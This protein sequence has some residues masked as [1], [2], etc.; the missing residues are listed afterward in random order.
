MKVRALALACAL[1][2]C[3]DDAGGASTLDFGVDADRSCQTDEGVRAV[4]FE[5]SCGTSRCHD[6]DRPR[7]D[8]D[9]VSDGFAER[10]MSATSVHPRCRE[11]ALVLPGDPADSLLI[12]KILGT[13]GA[14][15]DP[16][17]PRDALTPVQRSCVAEWVVALEGR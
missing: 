14:C 12:E 9:L 11:R 17:P 7:A 8:L 1:A 13:H 3:G 6:A 2:A 10:L 4:V 5:P 15:G 16:M